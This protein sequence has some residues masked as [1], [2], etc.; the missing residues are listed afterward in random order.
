MQGMLGNYLEQSARL[1][2]EMQQRMQDQ[3]RGMFSSFP[4]PGFGAPVQ[5]PP[6]D[7]SKR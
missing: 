5:N 4:F 3:T 2:I 6:D 1:F 7:E